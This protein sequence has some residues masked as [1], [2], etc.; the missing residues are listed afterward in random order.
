MPAALPIG[1]PERVDRERA[2][3]LGLR[4]VV[5]DHRVRRRDAAGFA[6]ADADAREEERA[7]SYA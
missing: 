2:G 6:D 3:T 4:E 1:M 7:R 5:R